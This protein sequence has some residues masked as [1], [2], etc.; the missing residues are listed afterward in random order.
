MTVEECLTPRPSRPAPPI[1]DHVLDHFKLTGRVRVITGASRG[2]GAAITESFAE[3]GGL[4]VNI[5][6]SPNRTLGDKAS[7]LSA[8]CGVTVVNRYCNVADLIV[9]EIHIDEIK[10]SLPKPI[11]EETLEEYHA[12]MNDN[13]HGVFTAQTL[14]A[15]SFNEQG[16]GNFIITGS[17]SGRLVTVTVDHVTYN[18]TKIAVTHL[19]QSLARE[20]REFAR[21]NIVAPGWIFM[22][23]SEDEAGANEARR[24]AVMG[25]FGDVKELKAVYLYLASDA[26]SFVTGAEFTVDG[27]YTL[28]RYRAYP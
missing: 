5:Y 11:L 28:P 22:A 12:Q 19:G 13:A 21:V 27:G 7:A 3:A 24:M 6:Q 9:I 17:I 2:N 14:S 20:W 15:K 4:I 16:F 25:R 10:V 23:M 8:R 1:A 18:M 26:S